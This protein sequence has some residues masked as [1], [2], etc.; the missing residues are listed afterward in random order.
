MKKPVI[1]KR[2]GP[3][4]ILTL[5][6]ADRANPLSSQMVVALSLIHI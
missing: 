5:N 3:V 1:E 2:D 6:D 4:L